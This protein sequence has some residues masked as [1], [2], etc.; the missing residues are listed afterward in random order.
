M[1]RRGQVLR[2]LLTACGAVGLEARDGSRIPELLETALIALVQSFGCDDLQPGL[3]PD[4][5]APGAPLVVLADLLT[6]P[7]DDDDTGGP[8]VR[9]GVATKLGGGAKGFCD[10]SVLLIRTHDLFSLASGF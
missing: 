7:V 5:G 6:V 10:A 3:V 8:E 2:K 9:R 4:D 1:A